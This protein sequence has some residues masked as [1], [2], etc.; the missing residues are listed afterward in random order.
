MF[1]CGEEQK[2]TLPAEVVKDE[3]VKE[4]PPPPPEPEVKGPKF[5]FMIVGARGIR[6]TDWLPGLGKP[7]CY[8]EV[9]SGGQLIHTTRIINDTMVP[10]WAEEFNVDDLNDNENLEFKVYDKDVVG[11]DYLGKVVLQPDAFAEKGCCQ[12]FEMLEAGKNI[13][14]Y[15]GLK[16]KTR[17]QEEYPAGPPSSFE[18]EVE[19]GEEAKEYGLEIDSQDMKNLQIAQVDQ[20]CFKAYNEKAD[21]SVQVVISDFIVSVNGVEGSADMVKQFANPKVKVKLVRALNTAV[22][23]EN[24]DKKKKHGLKFP[25]K[26]KNDVLVVLEI[27]D[28]YIKEYND[29]CAREQRA[30]EMV[31]PYDRIVSV[32]DEVGRALSLKSALEK[33]SG[34]FQ[35]GIQRPCPPEAATKAVGGMFRFF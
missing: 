9:K 8:C 2:N 25:T 5:V 4:E 34:K 13:K 18:V 35:I 28:G 24:N 31:L 26:M 27:G 17:G 6:N 1:C 20:G 10:R 19:K 16:M 21:S 3:A 33:A 32:K 29:T 12:D 15:L 22:L 30:S 7:D 11:S 23:L 14:A